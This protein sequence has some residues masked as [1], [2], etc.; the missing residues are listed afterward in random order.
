MVDVAASFGHW[1]RIRRKALD[2]TQAEL[3][4]RAGCAAETLRKIEADARHPSRS[5]AESL[6]KALEIPES[7]RALFIKVARAERSVDRLGPPTQDLPGLALVPGRTPTSEAITS[8]FT[9]IRPTAQIIRFDGRSPY[10]GLEAFEEED[11][12]LFFG[13]ERVVEDLLRRVEESRTVFVIGPSGSGKSSLVRAG[14]LPA[15][16]R[17][18]RKS[19]HSERWLYETM[20]PGRDPIREVARIISSMAGTTNAGGEV[21]GNAEDPSLF[22]Q[23]CE[24][25]LREGRDRRAVIFVDQFEEVF[26]QVSDEDER[27]AFLSM[28]THAITS[29]KGRV[30]V[31]FAMRSDFVGN[32]ATY[33]QL[34]TV[35]N[36]QSIQ[37][38]AMEIDEL[39]RAIAQPAINVGLHIDLD[40]VEQIIEDMRG[41][42]GA[43]PLMQ[44]TLKDLFDS[45]HAK[46]DVIYL[47]LHDYLQ[48]GGI[49]KSLERHA[50]ASFTKLQENEQLLARAIFSGLIEI[51]HGTQDTRRTAIFDELIPSGASP[52][53]VKRTIRKLA[54]A[55]LIT[56]DEQ[57]GKDT[58][59]ISHEKL[60]DAWP[61]L[62]K[63]VNE[64][65]EAIA[66]QNEIANA[67]KEWEEH[68]R[69]A[70]YLYRGAR[71]ANA[72]EQ[73]QA[74]KL[75]LSG[76]AQDF[77]DIGAATYT[78]E[79]EEAKI[80]ADRLLQITK[81]ALARQLAAQAQAIIANWNTRQMIAVLLAIQSMKLYATSEA[82]QVLLNGNYAAR[83]IACMTHDD[84]VTSVAFSPNGNYV[85]SGSE[86]GTARVWEV[87]TG[88]EVA[89]MT[90]PRR[91]NSHRS[92]SADSVDFS[93]DGKYIVSG[94]SDK[95]ARVW[96]VGTGKEIARMT[97]DH[98][99]LSVAFSPNGN[100]VASG[101]EDGTA[102]VWEAMT[103]KEVARMTH[104][105]GVRGVAFSPNGKHAISRSGRDT[106]LIWEVSTG[107]LVRTN[108]EI[109]T[110][111]HQDFS[112]D[113]R[114]E[115]TADDIVA[116]VIDTATG[117]EVARM[118]HDEW[119][120]S[121]AFSPDGIQV[122]SG[123][124]DK[125][126]RV[127]EIQPRRAVLQVAHDDVVNSI[128]FS[129]DGKYLLSGSDDKTARIWEVMTG[130]E[131]ARMTH[132][133]EV[134]SVAFSPDGKYVASASFDGTAR[135]W[136]AAAGN[137][138]ARME[139]AD[140]TE[141]VLPDHAGP[142]SE[143]VPMTRKAEVQSIA[144]SPDGKFVVSVSYDRT[145]R[146]WEA[147]TG[148]EVARMTY[149]HGIASVAF[150]PDGKYV[151]ATSYQSVRRKDVTSTTTRRIILF[152]EAMTGKEVASMTYDHGSLNLML[153]LSP[154]GKYV[155][156]GG[157]DKTARVWEAMTDKEVARMTHDA[158]VYSLAISP[159]GKYVVSGSGDKTARVW[160]VMTGREV[161]RM[162]HDGAVN[163]V[164]FS[165]DGKYVL[166]GSIDGTARVW[167]TLTGLEVVRLIHDYVAAVVA[168][169]P[170][171]RAI[172][173]GHYK[174]IQIWMWQPDDLIS[175]AC[176]YL[177][178][179]LT[180]AEWVQYI[181]DSL[182]Y[183]A[184][185]PNLPIL[186]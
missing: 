63:L 136:E 169:S 171:G 106:D 60:I 9:Q 54:D 59:T 10:K 5:M 144:F 155:V 102:R 93:P 133:G 71:L 91:E 135:V 42:P 99:V 100:Y 77:I 107:K 51:G 126:V 153:I 44:F 123:S 53:E 158:S 146:V 185:C 181:G 35:F 141:L 6:A 55:R 23:W 29:E 167:G 161:A 32:C 80:N 67:A 68:G 66:M 75:V 122:V 105:E 104:E 168:F 72:Q 85:A 157:D 81:V 108:S 178:R 76:L 64:N 113:G 110:T 109:V 112:R 98:Y 4:Q 25:A 87:A 90:H 37:I 39:V 170:D 69:D 58:V 89:R 140:V 130:G 82:A 150:S 88:K 50:D 17:G 166:S 33:P 57:A 180:R 124:R 103:G 143:S 139:H 179:N 184:V 47:T 62:K 186:H 28:L 14:L 162:R 120:S 16:K 2:L 121:V 31:L 92:S 78:N 15:L 22:S 137:E 176:E 74:R 8:F 182:P 38:G 119:V 160:E 34:N 151:V 149:D 20:T 183:E 152:W 172:A 165:P 1:V 177:P 159:D 115:V 117:K 65:R 174:T 21:L 95:T 175:M 132:D 111:D 84:G 131:V 129:P 142:R 134:L 12:D 125:T 36:Q 114:Y 40:L 49:H 154:D 156:S 30:I 43:L 11:V 83:L 13:R 164:A 97:H 52:S 46:G 127:W 18:G 116:R 163:S 118:T 145:I 3:A 45:Q 41:E 79:L 101:S 70:S 27:L 26:T 148:K 173:S 19:L 138:L 96:E 48:R 56:T 86:D 73:L 24:I 7:E 94:S 61:W 147:T 128:V